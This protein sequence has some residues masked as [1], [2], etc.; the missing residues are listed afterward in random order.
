MVRKVRLESNRREP[1]TLRSDGSIAD[2]SVESET[3]R[4]KLFKIHDFVRLGKFYSEISS[5]KE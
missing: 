4:L 2:F 1:I 5:E 3:I